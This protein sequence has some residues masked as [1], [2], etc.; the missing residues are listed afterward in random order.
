MNAQEATTL[1]AQFLELKKLVEEK[2]PKTVT[3]SHPW[4]YDGSTMTYELTHVVLEG[5]S[6]QAS[7]TILRRVTCRRTSA[8]PSKSSTKQCARASKPRA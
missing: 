3:L 7:S 5:S 8:T 2:V 1:H 4:D 6:H